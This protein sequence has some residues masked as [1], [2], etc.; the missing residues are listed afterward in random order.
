MHKTF[1]KLI[2][3]ISVSIITLLNRCLAE[4]EDLMVT[5][6]KRDIPVAGIVIE[7]IQSEGGDNEASPEFFRGLQKIAKKVYVPSFCIKFEFNLFYT[8]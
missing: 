6:K 2:N 5:Y 4:V 3:I 7:P 8:V 1:K